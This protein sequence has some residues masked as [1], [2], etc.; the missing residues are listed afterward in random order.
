VSSRT[1]VGGYRSA[2][3]GKWT[4]NNVSS[5]R[6]INQLKHLILKYITI[7]NIILNYII[8]KYMT[9]KNIIL[10]YIIL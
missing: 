2:I 8:L 5:V 4:E 10:N 1:G 3:S 9:K 6:F 7:K